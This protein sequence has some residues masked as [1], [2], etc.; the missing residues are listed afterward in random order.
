MDIDESKLI[1]MIVVIFQAAWAYTIITCFQQRTL[2]VFVFIYVIK[3][4]NY[5]VFSDMR[6]ISSVSLDYRHTGWDQIHIW[7]ISIYEWGLKCFS[8]LHIHNTNPICATWEGRK[9]NLSHVRQRWLDKRWIS[10]TK[11][12]KI[13]EGRAERAIKQVIKLSGSWSATR[14]VISDL[15]KTENKTNII[16]P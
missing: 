9:W 11:A 14:Q 1:V 6:H 4:Q 8:Y 10:N 7:F 13:W 16:W 2:K 5:Y 15:N 3:I 12:N